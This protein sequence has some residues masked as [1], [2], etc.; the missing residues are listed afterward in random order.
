MAVFEDDVVVRTDNRRKVTPLK[1]LDRDT[2]ACRIDCSKGAVSGF[3]YGKVDVSAL[4]KDD[5]VKV[6]AA[7]GAR[8]EMSSIEYLQE[9]EIL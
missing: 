5:M 6:E 3:T 9:M 4:N 2:L 1:W 7:I 8:P